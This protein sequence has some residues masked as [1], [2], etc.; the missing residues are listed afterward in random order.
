MN[1]DS[2][3]NETYYP[4]YNEDEF[5]GILGGR[6]LTIGSGEYELSDLPYESLIFAA[7]DSLSISGDLILNGSEEMWEVFVSAGSLS[8][9]SGSSIEFSGESLGIGAFD[10]INILNVDLKAQGE[11]SVRSLEDLVISN[12]DFTTTNGFGSDLIHLLAYQQ[13]EIDNLRFSD[14]SGKSLWKQ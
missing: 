13:L 9:S 12:S 8:I 14:R 3:D 5:T 10:S 2:I 7:T 11:I 6:E 4:S 1:P